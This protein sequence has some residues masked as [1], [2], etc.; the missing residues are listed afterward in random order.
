[1]LSNYIAKNSY[2]VLATGFTITDGNFTISM[3]AGQRIWLCSEGGSPKCTKAI[4]FVDNDVDYS[5]STPDYATGSP[6]YNFYGNGSTGFAKVYKA[7]GRY[8]TYI[9]VTSYNVTV[10]GG[11][12]FL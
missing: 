3:K 9:N 2:R 4:R 6:N 5:W 11:I 8:G 10:S 12:S 1:M 7:R